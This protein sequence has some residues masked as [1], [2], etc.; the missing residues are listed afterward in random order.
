MVSNST[1]LLPLPLFCGLN[2]I[3]G[4]LIYREYS[5]RESLAQHGF[6]H[7]ATPPKKELAEY[8]SG[9]CGRIHDVTWKFPSS[10][11]SVNRTKLSRL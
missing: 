10:S 2:K 9:S 11:S 3:L 7:A 4:P 8:M 1:V 6:I 5:R